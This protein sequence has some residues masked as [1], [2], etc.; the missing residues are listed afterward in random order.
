MQYIFMPAFYEIDK[1]R[2]LVVSTASGVLTLAEVLAHQQQLL[3]DSDFDPSFAYLVDFTQCTDLELSSDEIRRL[4]LKPIFSA[5]SRRAYL[6]NTDLQFGLVR[7]FGIL[8]ELSGEKD[9]HVFRD[10]RDA[11]QWVLGTN[12]V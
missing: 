11:L 7:M 3:E 1:Q 4:A 10:R 6:V 12:C 2:K 5:D 9:V 8:R